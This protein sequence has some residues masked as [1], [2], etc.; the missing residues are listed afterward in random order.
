MP[1]MVATNHKLTGG[2]SSWPTYQDNFPRHLMGMTRYLQ[3]KAMHALVEQHGH[4][5]LKYHYGSFIVLIGN[6]GARITDLG[7]QLAI[8]KQAVNQTINQIETA[9]YVRRQ[10]DPFD[11]RA[12]LVV[13]TP[14][15]EQ[16]LRQGAALLAEIES[17]FT[18]LIG[19]IRVQRLTENLEALYT[20]LQLAKPVHRRQGTPLGWLLPLVSQ[21]T[22]QRL[23]ELTSSRG[24]AGLKMSYV[25]VLSFMGP[26]GGRIQY[27]ARINEVSKQAIGA[28]ANELE[29]LGYLYR[30]TDT[31]D[32]RQVLLKLTADGMR[33]IEDSIGSITELEYQ[34]TQHVGQTA[35]QEIKADMLMLYEGLEIESEL[36]SNVS[37]GRDKLL[38][39]AVRLLQQLGTD[40]ARTL[41]DILMNISDVDS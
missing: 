27:M 10:P 16:L 1:D 37:S 34:F 24:H 4:R 7:E 26:Q 31:E 22:M 18:S 36:F 32:G 2:D 8:S 33:L 6:R 11:G 20:S 5:H 40:D 21:E 14:A 15:G 9:G 29:D 25:Q 17:E 3:S 41:A 35:M 38:T 13:L 23:M 28:I 12:K 30:E 39:M 19:S